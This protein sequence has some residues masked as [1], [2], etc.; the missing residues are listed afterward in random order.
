MPY[1]WFMSFRWNQIHVHLTFILDNPM[2]NF[3]FLS[4]VRQ[5]ECKSES[6]I[7]LVYLCVCVE[8]GERARVVYAWECVG[9]TVCQG[10]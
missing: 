2:K 5:W 4:K 9:V 1:F 7:E 6:P 8:K 3:A 10:V